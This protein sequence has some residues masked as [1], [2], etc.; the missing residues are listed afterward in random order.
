M[1]KVIPP[2][3]YL[4]KLSESPPYNNKNSNSF[5]FQMIIPDR[6]I[7]AGISSL[8]GTNQTRRRGMASLTMISGTGAASKLLIKGFSSEKPRDIA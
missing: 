5:T 7:I 8:L 4:A 3:Q 1:R 6:S 2:H